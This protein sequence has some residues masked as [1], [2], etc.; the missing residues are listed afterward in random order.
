MAHDLSESVVVQ[1]NKL[2][3]HG[4]AGAWAGLIEQNNGELEGTAT[5]RGSSPR[6]RRWTA[7][8]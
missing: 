8:W 2:R 1:F 3:L 7:S 6:P 5:S 4:M